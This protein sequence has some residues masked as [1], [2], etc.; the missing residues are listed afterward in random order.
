[1]MDAF[2]ALGDI[3]DKEVIVKRDWVA[4]GQAADYPEYRR[5]CGEIHGLLIARQ[6]TIDLKRKMEH[7]DNE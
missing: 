2:E 1:M 4:S 3:L 7:S 6:E 5:I